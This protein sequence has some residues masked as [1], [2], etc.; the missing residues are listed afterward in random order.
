MM[1]IDYSERSICNGI[2]YLGGQ[3]LTCTSNSLSVEQEAEEAEEAAEA[4]ARMRARGPRGPTLLLRAQ[5]QR[6]PAGNKVGGA[7]QS[8]TGLGRRMQAMARHWQAT[9]S[10]SALVPSQKQSSTHRKH[11]RRREA[12]LEPIGCRPAP[13]LDDLH[14]LG[15]RRR[16]R[17][18]AAREDER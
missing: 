3:L 1:G 2:P 9:A 16:W 4:P 13:S 18:H 11:W 7:G 14:H 5:K 17:V 12:A 10:T 15:P 6:E 8:A